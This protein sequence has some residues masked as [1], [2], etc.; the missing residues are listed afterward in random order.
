M[1]DTSES[2]TVHAIVD[3]LKEV[4]QRDCIKIREL[5]KSFGARSFLPVLM[6]PALLVVSPLSGI[7]LFSSACGITIAFIAGQ[8]VLGRDHLWLPDILM[9]QTLNGARARDAVQRLYGVA[10]WLDSHARRRL[11]LLM[12]RPGRKTIQML[13]LVCGVA[14]PFLE[15][16][17]FSSSV[18]GAVVL[19]FG[20]GLLLHDGL[21]ALLGFITMSAAAGIIL[22][23]LWS[24]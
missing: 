24:L 3:Q 20:T 5:I 19:L 7:P 16:V 23:A 10:D 13:C 1:S 22:T 6:L 18:L 14:M 8:M 4:S 12:R 9:R 11:N 17:P 2:Q 21:F 15:I